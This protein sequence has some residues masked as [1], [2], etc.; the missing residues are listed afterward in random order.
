[1]ILKRSAIILFSIGASVQLVAILNSGRFYFFIPTTLVSILII[2]AVLGTA[3]V[4]GFDLRLRKKEDGEIRK[5]NKPLH[6]TP[7]K[8]PS[9]SPEPDGRRP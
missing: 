6:G 2:V 7:A 8:A 3:A 5:P 4:A 9:S 1:M